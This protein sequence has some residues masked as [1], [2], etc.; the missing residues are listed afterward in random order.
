MLELLIVE[1]DTDI[2]ALLRRILEEAGYGVRQAYSG[3]EAALLLE[4]WSPD[5][6]LLDLMLPGMSGEA[7]LQKL[8]DEGRALPVLVLS[9]KGALEDKVALLGLGA[10]DYITKPFAPEEVVARVQAVLRRAGAVQP[11]TTGVLSY[12]NLTLHIEARTATVKDTPLT[13]TAKEFDILKLLMQQ[14]EKVYSKETLFEQVWQEGYYGADHTITVH[15]SNLRKKIKA[16]DPETAYIE[17]VYGIGFRLAA[18]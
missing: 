8:H 15:I 1:D 12:K 5:G 16:L 14:P 13:L 17:S 6:M 3:T 2:S 4:Q 11:T 9:A 18:N 10:D 7:L